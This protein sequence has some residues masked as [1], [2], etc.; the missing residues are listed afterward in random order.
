MIELKVKIVTKDI[1]YEDLKLCIGGKEGQVLPQTIGVDVKYP[2]GIK[3]ED[4]NK[5]IDT[6]E[7]EN[8]TVV[9]RKRFFTRPLIL[10]QRS[11]IK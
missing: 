5:D 2:N 3:E 10:M 8:N 11:Q 9:G 4:K 7:D 1:S 6:V